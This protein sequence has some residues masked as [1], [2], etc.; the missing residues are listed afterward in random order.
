MSG[1]CGF[2]S[3]QRGAKEMLREMN[4]TY[5]YKE[6][7][8]GSEE[9][10]SMGSLMVGFAQRKMRV[11]NPSEQDCRPVDSINN[12]ISAIMDGEVLNCNELKDELTEYPFQTDQELE[13]V[14]AA[15]LKWGIDFVKK[16]EGE[17]A[18]ALFD[19]EKACIY[20][21]RDRMGMRPLYYYM[22]KDGSVAFAS[23]L[24]ALM[25]YPNFEKQIN[26][27]VLAN[28]FV[29]LYIAAPNTIFKNTYK[30]NSG[31]ILKIEAQKTEKTAYWEISE[32]YK[33]AQENPLENYMEI[34]STLKEILKQSI[35][36]RMKGNLSLGS[37][38]S[39]GYD[40]TAICA[41]AQE[42]SDRA[43]TT[44]TVGFD[45]IGKNEAE[46]AQEIT[47]YL[48]VRHEKVYLTEK[49]V[50]TRTGQI[51]Y[52]YDEP[53][54]DPAIYPNMLL[55]EFAKGHGVDAVMS[56]E[57]GDELFGGCNI[58]A[59]LEKAQKCKNTGKL[60]HMLK[61]VPGLRGWDKWNKMELKYRIVSD[62]ITDDIKTQTGISQ[63]TD[64]LD[65]ILKRDK[66]EFY[67]NY[68]SKYGE[69]EYSITRML[70]DLDT[71]TQEELVKVDR[72]SRRVGLSSRFP[73]LDGRVM[74]F[75]FRVPAKYK[76]NNGNMKMLL[77][78][79]VYDYVPKEIMDR[80]KHGLGIPTD[81][82]L[83]GAFKEQILDW[84]SRDF[85]LKQGIFDPDHTISLLQT[86]LENGDEGIGSGNNYSQIWWP[87]F[88]FQQWY[89]TY[90]V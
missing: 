77:K 42:M 24:K 7:N 1:I 49:E 9:V 31:S 8:C 83:R 58:Y 45:K 61:S 82:W 54:A 36:L 64:A 6:D 17:F 74:E 85:L 11:Q 80:P 67:F 39:G 78:D 14:I 46:Y 23:E 15:Y 60:L 81:N 32:R 4:N 71:Y 55:S 89:A 3:N 68:E 75:V 19:R 20:L 21:I 41:L 76:V 47:K 43:I 44:F 10:Y 57:G 29:K 30:L 70:L 33:A 51:P 52:Y 28:Y 26:D 87:Y 62:D 22:G 79:I 65:R 69:K 50:L 48:G 84:T 40:S 25:K 59:I 18:I 88:I 73:M 27:E 72:A 66:N 56:G 34:K 13:I 2:I 53:M 38:I 86:Y 16:L 5:N 63:Y 37:F 90:M 12:R 35:S